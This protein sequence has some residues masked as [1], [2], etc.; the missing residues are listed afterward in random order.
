MGF[1]PRN[2]TWEVPVAGRLALE[3]DTVTKWS[4]PMPPVIIT[5]PQATLLGH[6]DQV[7]AVAFHPNG[8]MLASG[9]QDNTIRLWDLTSLSEKATLRGHTNAIFS[10]SFGPSFTSTLAP[11]GKFLA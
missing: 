4:I 5:Q 9:S 2:A 3:S 6:T 8:A 10:L 11:A 7:L 1:P